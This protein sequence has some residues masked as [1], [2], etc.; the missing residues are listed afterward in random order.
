MANTTSRVLLVDDEP[1]LLEGI[2]RNLGR[3]YTFATASDGPAAL[4]LLADAKEPFEVIVSDFRMPG[5]DGV[6]FLREA[7]ELSRDSTKLLLTGQWETST[8]ID[9]VNQGNVFRFLT[10]PCPIA[11]LSQVIAAAV[12]HYRLVTSERVLLEQTLRGSI[13]TLVRVLSLANPEAFGRANRV[14]RIV[15]DVIAHLKVADTWTYEVAAMLSQ[16]G[17]IIL[18]PDTLIK[19]HR[20]ESLSTEERAMADRLPAVALELLS[21][22]PRLDEVREILKYQTKQFD[23]TGPPH[24]RVKGEEIPLGARLLRI[25]LDYDALESAGAELNDTIA[26]LRHRTGIYD[27][28]LLD[29]VAFQANA[30]TSSGEPIRELSVAQLRAGMQ[31]VQDVRSKTGMLLV[32]RGHAVTYEMLERLRNIGARMGVS[33][34][35]RCRV[36]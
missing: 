32:S 4:K 2:V 16:L 34:P 26:T 10:K 3:K 1:T 24:D 8:A 14:K 21:G 33:E 29:I 11:T 18:P 15:T 23:G 35:I 9:A 13:Q 20:G 19:V 5:M 31:L 12:E 28:K 27:Q 7:Q 17:T 36:S 30:A 22:I 6:A 25:A